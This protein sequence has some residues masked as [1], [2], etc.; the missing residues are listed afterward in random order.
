M[1]Q[2]K[3]IM[4]VHTDDQCLTTPVNTIPGNDLKAHDYQD[5]LSDGGDSLGTSLTPQT[6][7][8]ASPADPP[9]SIE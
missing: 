2:G 3:D 1:V 5:A 4:P 9:V 7:G 6:A 8:G